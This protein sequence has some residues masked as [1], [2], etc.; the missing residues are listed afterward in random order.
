MLSTFCIFF[1][2]KCFTDLGKLYLLIWW[3]DFKLEQIFATA[4][5]GTKN[6]AQFKSCQL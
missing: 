6:E 2:T 5:A 3:L 4:P 1:D